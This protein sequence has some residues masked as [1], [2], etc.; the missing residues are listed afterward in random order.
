MCLMRFDGMR[1]SCGVGPC[2]DG[3][4]GVVVRRDEYP[5]I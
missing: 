3:D 5:S 1:E 4:S 2:D